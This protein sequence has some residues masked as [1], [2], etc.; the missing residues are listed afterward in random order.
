MN[1]G[2]PTTTTEAQEL[3]SMIQYYRYMFPSQYHILDF[4][5]EATSSRKGRKIIWNDTL[6]ESFKEPK[7]MVSA[8]TS[9][10]YPDWNIPFTIHTDAFDK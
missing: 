2:I 7:R 9:L 10:S 8:V 4:L 6:E 3:I 5:I 1:I